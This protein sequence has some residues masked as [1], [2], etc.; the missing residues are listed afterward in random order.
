LWLIPA[1]GTAG[2]GLSVLCA[3]A[4]RAALRSWVLRAR[5]GFDVPRAH[6]AGPLVAAA[7]GA[8]AALLVGGGWWA[9][10][11]ALACDALV[12][13]SWLKATGQRLALS[14]FAPAEVIPPP[15]RT[16]AR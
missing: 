16:T 11:A 1:F 3:Y 9:L 10:A 14:G 2:A 15:S 4:V 5:F 12:L 6:H 8:A 7:A 13:A